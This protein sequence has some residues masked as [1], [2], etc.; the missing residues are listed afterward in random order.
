VGKKVYSFYLQELCKQKQNILSGEN[1]KNWQGNKS[2]MEKFSR[3]PSCLIT[4]SISGF[5]QRAS[6]PQAFG[7]Q[8]AILLQNGY[9][10]KAFCVQ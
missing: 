8:I 2:V 3:P 6:L 5:L 7:K 10:S 9:K 1:V 4:G